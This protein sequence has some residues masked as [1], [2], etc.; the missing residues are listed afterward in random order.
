MP[1]TRDATR[2]SRVCSVTNMWIVPACGAP[3]R[4]RRWT[5]EGQASAMWP[6][7]EDRP[8]IATWTPLRAKLWPR[9]AEADVL[10]FDGTY[11]I[12]KRALATLS[13]ILNDAEF[14]P[15]SVRDEQ[16]FF[17]I[18][19]LRLVPLAS[20]ADIEVIAGENMQVFTYA[21]DESA[22]RDVKCFRVQEPP[23][24]PG[25]PHAG[26]SRMFVTEQTRD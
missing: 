3:P 20:S 16:P 11:A 15:L 12:R 4:C 6:L 7:F 13:V 25:A 26:T 9:S 21:F 18:H 8:L 23:G 2:A 17:V 22:L 14:L 24:A 5:Q 19:P 10:Y 1:V